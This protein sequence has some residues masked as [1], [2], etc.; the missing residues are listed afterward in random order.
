MLNLTKGQQKYIQDNYN[1]YIR[2]FEEP[3]IIPDDAGRSFYVYRN[4]EEYTNSLGYVQYCYNIDYLNG[5]LY[6]AVQARCGQLPKI[7]KEV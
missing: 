2:N 1:A 5:W 4:S 6:G 7:E 3:V